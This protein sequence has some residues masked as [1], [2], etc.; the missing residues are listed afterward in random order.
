MSSVKSPHLIVWES[1]VPEHHWP[2][3]LRVNGG[4]RPAD[5]MNFE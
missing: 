2:Q 4:N 5:S 1:K 3:G